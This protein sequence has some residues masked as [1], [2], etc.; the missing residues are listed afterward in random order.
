MEYSFQRYLSAKRTIDDRALNR[1]VWSQMAEITA[2]IQNKRGLKV[3]EVGA[4]IGTMVQRMLEWGTL[5]RASVQATDVL[6]ENVELV[7]ETLPIWAR[8]A[9]YHVSPINPVSF[10]LKKAGQEID[11][12]FE[13]VDVIDFLRQKENHAAY[14]LLIAH[15]FLDLFDLRWIIPQLTQL[16]CN[17][18]L[19]LFT[20]NFDGDT[21]FEPVWDGN[22]ENEILG[23]YHRSMDQRITDGRPSGDSRAGRHLFEVLGENNLEILASGSSD[24]VVFPREGQYPADEAYFLHHILSFFEKTLSERSE[25]DQEAL[26]AWLVKRHAQIA[27]GELVYI[28]HQLDFLARKPF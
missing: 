19:M 17:S 14:D 21:I 27:D 22:L 4:G 16:V 12:G 1:M 9:G 24:W 5:S 26:Q 28:A 18:G 10:H 20:I 6:A 25:V 15:A 23:A 7:C 3:L 13:A 8:R 11:V 2:G